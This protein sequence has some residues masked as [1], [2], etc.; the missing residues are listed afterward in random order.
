M[1]EETREELERRLE[2]LQ[3]KWDVLDR[4]LNKLSKLSL[5]IHKKLE[6]DIGRIAGMNGEIRD[7]KDKLRR[8]K[9]EP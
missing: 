8:L 1:S 7:L 5:K 4:Q 2:A 6:A 3:K 9:G